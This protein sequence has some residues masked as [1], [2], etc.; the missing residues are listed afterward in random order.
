MPFIALITDWQKYDYYLGAVKGYIYSLIPDIKI[1][2]VSHTISNYNVF[3]AAFILKS[4]FN[5][6][7]E[8][9]VFIIGVKS[10]AN[11]K[12]GYLCFKFQNRFI[13]TSDN[14]FF[15][16]FTDAQP[17]AVYCFNFENTTFPEKDIFAKY[18]CKILN[19]EKLEDFATQ[20]NEYKI[21]KNLYSIPGQSE[22]I[23]H[24]IYI[25]NYGNA[26]T[27]VTKEQFE[28]IQNNR[29]FKIFSGSNNFPI[30]KISETYL[31]DDENDLIALFNSLGL[32]EIAMVNSSVAQLFNLE[33]KSNIRIEFY[34]T[35]SS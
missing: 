28:R 2:D 20:I 4:C 14:G 27:N 13:L 3:Q 15:S 35:T 1:I 17:Q 9:T 10:V 32:L 5:N 21:D 33:V 30:E 18:A 8:G 23:G 24:I 26:I 29:K 19:N 22:I 11:S 34:D 25:D 12:N 6:F 16:V 7:A 31:E